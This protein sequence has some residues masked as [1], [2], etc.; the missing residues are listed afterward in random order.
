MENED[1]PKS[2]NLHESLV[3]I[4]FLWGYKF[5]GYNFLTYEKL[6]FAMIIVFLTFFRIGGINIQLVVK[7]HQ[8]G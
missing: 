7:T 3:L 6:V 4:L 5:R 2:K 8:V 1:F